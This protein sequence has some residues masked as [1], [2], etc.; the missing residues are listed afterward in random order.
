V[1]P[2]FA[3]RILFPDV[4]KFKFPVALTAVVLTLRVVVDPNFS[5]IDVPDV[6]AIAPAAALPISTV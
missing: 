5:V 4:T 3:L 2:T 6:T 1:V